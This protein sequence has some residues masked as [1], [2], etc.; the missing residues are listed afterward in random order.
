[1]EFPLSLIITDTILQDLENNAFKNLR[2]QLQFYYCYIDTLL[3]I[4]KNQINN[5]LN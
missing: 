4:P 1:M 2:L 5:V 3:A